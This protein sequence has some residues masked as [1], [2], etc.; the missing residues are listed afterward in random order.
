MFVVDLDAK[1]GIL[2]G[3]A[4]ESS[5]HVIREPLLVVLSITALHS[6]GR[7]TAFG[8]LGVVGQTA[9]SPKTMQGVIAALR[10]QQACKNTRGHGR[11]SG[12]L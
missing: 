4:P 8:A 11:A 1:L 3:F 5:E 6:I 12:G 2:A 9:N 10:L 7:L